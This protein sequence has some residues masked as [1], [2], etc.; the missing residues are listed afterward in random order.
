MHRRWF[1]FLLCLGLTLPGLALAGELRVCMSDV[2]HA[3]WRLA[4]ADG[5]VRERGLDFWLLR[6]FAQRSGWTFKVQHRSG[7]RCLQDL[8]SGSSDAAV[9]MSFLP[10]RE[11]QM[12]FPM[13]EGK[14]DES[15]AL[16]VDSYSWFV[17]R[18]QPV[19]WDGQQLKVPAQ[20][21]VAA[22]SGHS[23]VSVLTQQGYRVDDSSRSVLQTL[24][25]V[26]RG[27]VAA[28]ALPT[29]EGDRELRSNVLWSR[30]WV[31][32]DPPVSVRAYYLVFSHAF[33]SRH[34]Q[35]LPTLWRQ[36][37]ELTH[38]PAYQQAYLEAILT[39]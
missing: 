18:G 11:S 22:Q 33:A 39:P 10:Q 17:P 28:A 31:R 15:L 21:V 20:A 16:R 5:R 13:K 38:G 8:A 34:E 27:Q 36:F 35:A 3:P 19:A 2:P 6:Q 25:K 29:S 7:K 12:R 9:G 30:K 24:E 32:L 1:C 14:P 23:I 4:D 26:G 37:F